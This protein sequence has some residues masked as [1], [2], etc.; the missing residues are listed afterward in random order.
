MKNLRPKVFYGWWIV[1]AGFLV[2]FC[3]GVYSYISGQS[4]PMLEA[5]T[6]ATS[7][8]ELAT[9][10]TL[11]SVAGIAGTIIALA[12]ALLIDRHGP[13]RAMLIGIPIAGISVMILSVVNS[14]PAYYL[15][16][17]TLLTFGRQVGFY[18][19]VVAAAANW[20][21][22]RRSIALGIVS[23]AAAVGG[24]AFSSLG[25]L[26]SD[27]L[28]RQGAFLTL[29]GAS[30]LVGVPLAFVMRHRP[31]QHGYR[32]D[33][34]LPA[35]KGSAGV[36]AEQKDI[37]TE[38]DFSLRQA[39]RTRAF[40]MLAAAVAL[41]LQMGSTLLS[42]RL[43]YLRDFGPDTT[44][45]ALDGRL[46]GVA[47]ILVFGY[48]G[49][50]FSK[51]HLLAIVV[52]LQVASVI[53][54]VAP[55]SAALFFTHNLIGIMGSGITPLA[56]AIRADYFGRR[57]FAT[58]TVVAGVAVM[59]IGVP[60]SAGLTASSISIVNTGGDLLLGTIPAIIVGI[61][62]AGLFLFA[63]PPKRPVPKMP[64]Q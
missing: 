40:W 10:F 60:L 62:S 47:V 64:S 14:L 2:A 48:L 56:L 15:L 59:V 19:P 26:L 35:T 22:K 63:R 6:G 42:A 5:L 53:V 12:G 34:R 49:D 4:M 32:P 46:L 11:L 37:R 18:L 27:E 61:V 39:L 29:G 17:G 54:L 57:S 43:L 36:E 25:G 52:A 33:G 16:Q 31:E 55:A 44:A 51:R 58:V 41:S 7:P 3:G 9:G 20:F 8:R 24:F 23:A 13:R 50:K 28:G 38:T 30:L 45:V 21:I 1:A